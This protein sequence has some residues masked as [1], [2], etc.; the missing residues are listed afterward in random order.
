MAR[1]KKVGRKK[2]DRYRFSHP[3]VKKRT[4]TEA[5]MMID[6]NLTYNDLARRF[7]LCV[8]TVY[9]DMQLRLP[10]LDKELYKQ[11]C[12]I[13]QRH[14]VEAAG[15]AIK[16]RMTKKDYIKKNFDLSIFDK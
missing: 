3:E 4:L 5:R 10:N 1:P 8:A 11:I 15:R 13:V 16:A 2:G 9:K 6:E 14:Q 7:D 12:A